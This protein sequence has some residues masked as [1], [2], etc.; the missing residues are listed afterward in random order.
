MS[1]VDM[2]MLKWMCGNARKDMI[3]NKAIHKVGVKLNEDKIR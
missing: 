3:R 1:V 2:K